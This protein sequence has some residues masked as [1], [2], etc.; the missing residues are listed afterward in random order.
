[1]MKEAAMIGTVY[2]RD[3]EVREAQYAGERALSSLREAERQL[4]SA[5][6][7]GI[8]DI[9]GG[10][11]ISGLFKHMK[12][13]NASQCVEEAKRDLMAF[14]NELQDIRGIE[15]LN[16]DIGGFLT[17][18][19]FFFDGLIA[20]VWVQSKINDARRQVSDAIQRVEY[21]LRQLQTY[22]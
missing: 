16:V 14:R 18:A 17:F 4:N 13:N 3:K 8:V 2:D 20:D 9:F 19:D 22:Y 11:T 21:I 12:V 10:D 15:N 6:N 7:W 5:R 1:M